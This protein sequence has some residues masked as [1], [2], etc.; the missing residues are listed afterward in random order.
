MTTKSTL[1]IPSWFVDGKT[2][3][4]LLLKLRTGKTVRERSN[5][6]IAK[7]MGWGKDRVSIDV[8]RLRKI[9]DGQGHVD[10]EPLRKAAALFVQTWDALAP[11]EAERLAEMRERGRGPVMTPARAA[12]I[13]EQM[14]RLRRD[15]LNGDGRPRA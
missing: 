13:A 11:T 6:S 10:A 14:A 8:M 9:A 1:T 3:E 12:S 7:A 5:R 15:H 2:P 4:K